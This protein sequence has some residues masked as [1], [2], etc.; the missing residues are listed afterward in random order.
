[1]TKKMFL[2]ETSEKNELQMFLCWIFF[3]S[4][5]LYL[6]KKINLQNIEVSKNLECIND[7]KSE[8]FFDY[9]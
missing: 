1:M 4:P 5:E 8:N 2:N 3:S 7:R 9:L 6:Q